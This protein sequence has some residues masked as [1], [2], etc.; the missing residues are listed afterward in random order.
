MA[1]FNH[2]RRLRGD[3]EPEEVLK[4]I[5]YYL[6]QIDG[7]YLGECHDMSITRI[8]LTFRSLSNAKKVI[9]WMDDHHTEKLTDIYRNLFKFERLFLNAIDSATETPSILTKKSLEYIQGA[10]VMLN[11]NMTFQYCK[12]S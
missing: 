9:I 10:L 3:E 8:A 11:D 6:S 5:E 12:Y 2:K 7:C 4:Y 1:T